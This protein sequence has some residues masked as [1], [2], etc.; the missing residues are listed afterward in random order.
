VKRRIFVPVAGRDCRV[1]ERVPDGEAGLSEKP[2]H[3]R[4]DKKYGA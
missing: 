3:E 2:A 4:L 1:V